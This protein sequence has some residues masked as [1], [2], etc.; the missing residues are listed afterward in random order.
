MKN[1]LKVLGRNGLG[2]AYINNKLPKT[3]TRKSKNESCRTQLRDLIKVD[4]FGSTLNEVDKVAWK[5]FEV[6]LL[7]LL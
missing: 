1:F 5:F 7:E 3:V 4:N 6:I 2:F